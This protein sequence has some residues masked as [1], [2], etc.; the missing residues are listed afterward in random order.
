MR[1]YLRETERIYSKQKITILMRITTSNDSLMINMFTSEPSGA[2]A[3][4]KRY[5][6]KE[7]RRSSREQTRLLWPCSRELIVE[8]EICKYP[9]HRIHRIYYRNYTAHVDRSY[10]A[11][12]KILQTCSIQVKNMQSWATIPI[13][14]ISQATMEWQKIYRKY[15]FSLMK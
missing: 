11:T 1:I 6:C 4:K 12:A 5:V 13:M 15:S 9:A 7:C 3:P 14:A 2:Y 10:P 8:I